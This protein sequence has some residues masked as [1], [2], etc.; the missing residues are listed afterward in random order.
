MNDIPR[1]NP[2]EFSHHKARK[3]FGQNFLHD[4]NIVRRIVAAV[5]PQKNQLILEIGPG[6]GAITRLLLQAEPRLTALELDRDLVAGLRQ[7]FANQPNLTL[8]EGDALTFSLSRIADISESTSIGRVRVVGNL[9][10]NISTPLLFHL[11]NQRDHV[12]D[13]HFMLQ[14][15]LVTRLA[16]TAGSKDYGR[17][18]VI[19]QY[20]CHVI[21]L[22]DVPPTAF[23]PQPK[24]TSA[25]VRLQPRVPELA[26]Q[27]IHTLSRVVST[28]FQQRRKTLRNTLKPLFTEA[29]I[30]DAEIS[31]DARAETLSVVDF[32]R[33]TNLLYTT[34]N[35]AQ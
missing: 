21:D 18:S 20:H 16:A 1:L 5:V 10:Y 30:I 8:I 26:A 14:K 32:V 33:L 31:P 22:F 27:D 34:T 23:F 13:M 28:A 25:I 15:E 9:P 12:M 4:Q 17:L 3:R 2:H 6:Q 7:V 11:L 35:G 29:Q 24:V 19:A